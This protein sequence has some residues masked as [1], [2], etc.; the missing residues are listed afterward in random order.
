M[1]L[2]VG[3]WMFKDEV[4]I[5]LCNEILKL[6]LTLDAAPAQVG[7]SAPEN[8]DKVKRDSKVTWFHDD[9][10]IFELINPLVRKANKEAGWNFQY[11]FS[12]SAQFTHYK[13]GQYYGWHCDSWSEPYNH[14]GARTHNK[15]RKL[16]SI[17][18]LSDQSEYTG[19]VL[20]L[21]ARQDDPDKSTGHGQLIYIDPQVIPLHQKGD[22]IIF[23][24]FMWH[25]VTPVASGV[26]YSLPMWYV[27]DPW[28]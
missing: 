16:S 10:W 24:S 14:P 9:E 15:I 18:M 6:G 22:L 3:C 1:N 7:G 12:E 4:P 2:N 25:R 11:D 17:L 28:K 20:E 8:I 26:R 19:G 27:G 23:P 5:R 13:P 21:D